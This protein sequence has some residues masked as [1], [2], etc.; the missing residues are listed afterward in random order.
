MTNGAFEQTNDCQP[1]S[2]WKLS[3]TLGG[4]VALDPNLSFVYEVT[5]GELAG[6]EVT[7]TFGTQGN[8]MGTLSYK[9]RFV[10]GGTTYTCA[11]VT[12]WSAKLQ[13]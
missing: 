3:I 8:V 12:S 13:R 6:S 2:R 5:Q 4:L 9:A 1:S 7:G 10:E 11:N